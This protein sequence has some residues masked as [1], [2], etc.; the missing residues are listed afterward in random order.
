M[1]YIC[2]TSILFFLTHF[3][4]GAQVEKATEALKNK[5]YDLAI[6]LYQ[7][8]LDEGKT[9]GEIHYNMGIAYAELKKLGYAI[10]HFQLAEKA[11]LT[12]NDLYHNLQ[13]VKEDRKDEIEVIPEF[14]LTKWWNSWKGLLGSNIWSAIA[15]IFVFGGVYGL[16][17]WR[18]ARDRKR[19]KLGFTIAI[20]LIILAGLCFVS[21]LSVSEDNINPK[22]GVLLADNFDLRFAPDYD[23][24]QILTI[25]S[26]V[27]IEVR[28]QIGEWIKVRLAN[29]QVGWL[30]SQEVGLF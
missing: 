27:D 25:H 30:P 24:A 19:R 1:R 29:G 14:F 2:F 28:D 9:S 21:A 10:W 5:E 16:F 6:Q 3:T 7:A 18:L 26:G 15:L 23:S 20:P 22:L 17:N 12:S 13:L 4:L 8:V 11:G